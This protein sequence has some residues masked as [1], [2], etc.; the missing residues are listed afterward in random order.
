MTGNPL[1]DLLIFAIPAALVGLW[2]TGSRARELAIE[3]A[4]RA[5]QQ[6]QL[7]FLD[8]TA[9][10]RSLKPKRSQT[11]STCLARE[12]DFEFTDAGQ[13]RDTATVTMHG[14][15]LHKVH[16]PYTRDSEGNRIYVH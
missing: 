16:F 7:Q 10:L 4:R 15:V 14:P 11:G 12:F 5:C 13:F 3:H 2:W 9:A 8:Q 1:L 6:R